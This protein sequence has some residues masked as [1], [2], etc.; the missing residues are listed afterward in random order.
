MTSNQKTPLAAMFT[1]SIFSGIKVQVKDNM[2]PDK[3][4]LLGRLKRGLLTEKARGHFR[5]IAGLWWG[6][7]VIGMVDLTDKA[8]AEGKSWLY[9]GYVLTGIAGCEGAIN[10][11]EKALGVEES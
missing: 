5:F 1:P 8:G 2:H 3:I 6:D 4:V 9:E 7:E 10:K 11:F